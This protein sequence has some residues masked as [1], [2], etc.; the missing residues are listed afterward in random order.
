MD[1]DL[2]RIGDPT[3]HRRAVGPWAARRL[4]R[5]VQYGDRPWRPLSSVVEPA[6]WAEVWTY[7]A[8]CEL[9][10]VDR[11]VTE[12]HRLLKPGGRLLFLEHEGRPGLFGAVQRASERVYSSTPGGCHVRHDVHGALRRGGFDIVEVDRL[13]VPSV[14]PL[15]RHWVRGV[16][17][18]RA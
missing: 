6:E 4:E 2:A 12:L 16:A 10:D 11:A 9:G 18:S 7:G 1:L 3:T 13:T 14:V 5:G 17:R 8:L 15:L